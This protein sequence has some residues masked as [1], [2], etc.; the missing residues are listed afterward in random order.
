VRIA[1]ASGKG[2]TGKTTLATNLAT[3]AARAGQ[4]VAYL[5]CDVE[6]PNGHLFLKPQIAARDAVSVFVPRVNEQ[7]CSNC[8]ECARI[9]QYSAIVCLGGKPLVFP[10]LCH[11]CGGCALVCPQRAIAEEARQVGV[12]ER[13][14]AGA[15]QFMHGLL[16]VGEAMS[17]PVIRAVRQTAPRVDYQIIDAPPGTSCPMM[18]AVRDCDY[19]L[20]VTEPTPFGLNDLTL[21]VETMRQLELPFG[22]V[23]NRSDAGDERVL[24]YCRREGILIVLE[25]PDD[26]RIAEA[27]SRGELAVDAVRGLD[28]TLIRMLELMREVRP[29]S[30]PEGHPQTSRA[31]P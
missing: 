9:C 4:R 19:V 12:V 13:G 28:T 3:V 24:D 21:A 18:T 31:N 8:G 10:E 27:Y 2:G 17:P 30:S 5:D 1:I 14:K 23:I 15:I 11:G 29:F 26:R 22:V 6:E 20:L 16:N 25:L 7:A